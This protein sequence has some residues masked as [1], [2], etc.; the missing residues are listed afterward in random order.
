MDQS[1][2]HPTDGLDGLQMAQLSDAP[3]AAPGTAADGAAQ[4]APAP[5]EAPA[6]PAESAPAAGGA[7]TPDSAPAADTPAADSAPGAVPAEG[8]PAGSGLA[9]GAGTVPDMSAV[10]PAPEPALPDGPVDQALAQLPDGLGDPLGRI[11]D[12]L[13]QGGAVVWAI[14]L[15]SVLTLAV[16]LWRVVRLSAL[17]AWSAKRRSEQSLAAWTQGDEARAR[18]LVAGRS[19][20]RSKLLCAAY[21]SIALHHYSQEDAEAEMERVARGLLTEARSGLKLLELIATIAPL[22]G[23]LGTVI[24]MIS[25]FQA[26]QEAGSRADPAMLAGG[27]W[28]ALLTTAAGMA[29]A[30]PATM[31][32]SWLESVCDRLAH[33]FEDIGTRVFLGRDSAAPQFRA[34]AE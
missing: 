9:D 20:A 34:A 3:V 25:A 21:D 28:E 22:L 1:P 13:N 31:A 8:A 6:E 17:G 2:T 4:G 7:P 18:A 33:D 12:F 29:V 14:A 16:I 19:S 26:L 32:L 5:A 27:I 23:L 15:L 30:I 24:G 11:L 10:Q